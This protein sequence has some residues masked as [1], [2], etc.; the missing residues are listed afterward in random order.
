MSLHFADDFESLTINSRELLDHL[1]EQE[2]LPAMFR[3]I[4]L[5]TLGNTRKNPFFKLKEIALDESIP[6]HDRTQAVRYMNRIPHIDMLG[7]VIECACKIISDD[8]YPIRERYFFFSNNEK[9]IRLDGHTVRACHHYYFKL[10][11]DNKSY[12]LILRLLSAEY[13]YQLENQKHELWYPARDFIVKLALDKNES[14]FMRSEAADVLKRKITD[15]DFD[16]GTIVINELGSLYQQNRVAT[17]YTNAQNAHNEAIT[18]SVMNVVR[19]LSN[20][21]KINPPKKIENLG[22]N[23]LLG[24]S[25]ANKPEDRLLT[26]ADIYSKIIALPDEII[27]SSG[28]NVPNTKKQKID[29][30]FQHI[31]IYPSRYE[32]IC[33]SDILVFV[34]RKIDQ[35]SPEIKI[36]LEKRLMDELFDMDQ[37]CGT[38]YL[39]RIINTLSGYIQEENLQIKM[40]INDQLRANIFARLGKSLRVLSMKDQDIILAEISSE[41][42]KKEAS[43][44]FLELCSDIKDELNK[45]FVETKLINKESFE[46][47]YKKCSNDFIGLSSKS[48]EINSKSD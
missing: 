46:E 11:E 20:D 35:Q 9:Y 2:Y 27:D 36:E 48:S 13:I 39:T 14:V 3:G 23:S 15:E 16:I 1:G 44:E 38:G 12:P 25:S 32:G 40:N 4:M 33:L 28:N 37:T 45:E 10:S 24:F 7:N 17:I 29:A 21:P 26:S 5:N 43:I 22:N 31:L 30:A 6:F 41:D 18:E 19:T 34:W 47:I 42:S 8:R